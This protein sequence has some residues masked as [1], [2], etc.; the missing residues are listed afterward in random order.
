MKKV[1]LFL[2]L[3]I[4]SL[5]LAGCGKDAEVEAFIAENDAVM[6]DITT[7]IDQNPT[8]AGVDEAQKSFDAKKASLKTKWDAIKDA[9]NMQVSAETQKK[10]NDSVANNMKTLTDVSTKNAA[11]LAQDRDALT[12]FQKLVQEYAATLTP[13]TAK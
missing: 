9:R 3:A 8:A 13:P 7:K 5:G 12:K 10:L 4:L 11:K 1:T 6:K 2:L